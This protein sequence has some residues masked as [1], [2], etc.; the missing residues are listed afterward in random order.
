MSP[1]TK[2]REPNPEEY[3]AW[4]RDVTAGID[5]RIRSLQA[6]R[7]ELREHVHQIWL[8]LEGSEEVWASIAAKATEAV[9]VEPTEKQETQQRQV[10]PRSRRASSSGGTKVSRSMVNEYVEGVLADPE[11][12]IITQTEIKARILQN[13]PDSKVH[14]LR[15]AIHMRLN[16]LI[17]EGRLVKLETGKAGS[18]SK[19]VRARADSTEIQLES[20]N[21]ALEV[22]PDALSF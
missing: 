1:E 22:E 19:Y 20:R 2:T 13:H 18:P 16:E 15:S 12:E 6:Q 21:G 10:R 4:L 14:S 17:D 9:T 8:G 5:E 11:I 3:E 7:S